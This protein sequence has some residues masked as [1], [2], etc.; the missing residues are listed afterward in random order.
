MTLIDTPLGEV[1][2]CN[3]HLHSTSEDERLKE[4]DAIL[5]HVSE[6][7]HRILLG[8]FNSLSSDDNYDVESLEVEARFD[9]TATLRQDYVDIASRLGLDDRSTS[10]TPTNHNPDIS[11][12]I[13]I[14]YIFVTRSLAA[15]FINATVIKTQIS[16]QA[17]DH[18]PFVAVTS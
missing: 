10:P 3:L 13:R 16:D 7:E 15:S 12:P 1:A 5:N 4:L 9:L 8:D 14:D 6:H 18:Y 2:I 11:M 17:S